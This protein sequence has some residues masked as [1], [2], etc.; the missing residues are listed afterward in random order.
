MGNNLSSM[1]V[2]NLQFEYCFIFLM[3]ELVCFKMEAGEDEID[4][5]D[6]KG[7]ISRTVHEYADVATTHGIYYI[8]ETGRLMFERVF[9]VIVVILALVFAISFSITAYNNWKANPVLTSVGTT[10]HP[11]EKIA[12]PSITICPQGSANEIID[13]ALFKQFERYLAGKGKMAYQLSENDLKE[14]GISFLSLIY[15]GAKQGPTQMIRMLGSPGLTPDKS[16]EAQALLNPEDKGQCTNQNMNDVKLKCPDGFVQTE[17][18]ADGT[19]ACWH[20]KGQ[21]QKAS[22]YD[23]RDYCEGLLGNDTWSLFHIQDR[24]FWNSLWNI[25]ATG[26]NSSIPETLLYPKS[27]LI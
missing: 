13:V 6:A 7:P 24:P 9:W 11:I 15:P 25:I 1:R 12:F 18:F 26:I 16:I 14:E 5:N 23:G 8:F 3:V 22:R 19:K 20:F 21:T 2:I 10:G 27:N 4:K 17:N